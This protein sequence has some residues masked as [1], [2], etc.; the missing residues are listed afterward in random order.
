M[1]IDYLYSIINLYLKN[2]KNNLKTNLNISKCDQEVI[3][4]LNMN[5][6]NL[7]KTRINLPLDIINPIIN[8]ILNLYKNKMMII[9]EKYS[10]KN[11]NCHYQV[12]FKNGRM[13]SLDGFSPLE[14]NNIR[15][16]LYNINF[17]PEEIRLDSLNEERKMAYEP[18][19][20]LQQAGF[21]SYTT[22]FLVALFLTDIFIIAL[23]IFKVLTK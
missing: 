5:Q 19:L 13:L 4:S 10:K 21:T 11:N 8:N 22:L 1:N 23:W 14:I 12:L 17:N 16:N 9:D 18:K 6:S 2:E 15:N 7:D 3:F 20:N